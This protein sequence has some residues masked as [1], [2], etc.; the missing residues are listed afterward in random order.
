[1]QIYIFKLN[2]L[3]SS[4]LKIILVLQL[5]LQGHPG[6]PNKYNIYHDCSKQCQELWGAGHS[7]PSS[8]YLRKKAKMLAKYPLPDNWKE[9]YDPGL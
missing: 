5:N 6:C 4:F 8:S 7:E 9:V 1:M 3:L 2:S